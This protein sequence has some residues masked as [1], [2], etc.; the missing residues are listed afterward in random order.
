[1]RKAKL[2]LSVLNPATHK[3]FNVLAEIPDASAFT[4]IGGTALSLQIGHRVSND[5]DFAVFAERLPTLKIDNIVAKI[6]GLGHAVNLITNPS[7]A[8]TFKIQMGESLD[9]FCRDYSI[10]NVK[11]TFFANGNN[12]QMR[13]FYR[14]TPTVVLGNVSFPILGLE[15]LKTTKILVL[16]RRIRSRDLFDLMVLMRDYEFSIAEAFVIVQN[17]GT[18]NDPEY[19]KAVM[20]G[21]IPLDEEDEGLTPVGVQTS[22]AEIYDF[23]EKAIEQYEISLAAALWRKSVSE[24]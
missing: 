11:I 6:K 3:I 8:S 23:F 14:K 22:L 7:E 18:N 10:D 24:K 17:L 9:N 4:L 20:T 12:E 2:K 13:N 16:A 15:G 21:K 19:Y 1:V 5:L